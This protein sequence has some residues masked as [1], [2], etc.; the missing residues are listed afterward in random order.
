MA[1]KSSSSR[2]TFMLGGT[3]AA[4]VAGPIAAA[5]LQPALTRS[6]WGPKRPPLVQDELSQWDHLVGSRFHIVGESGK[7]A[8]TL[9]AVV[10]GPADPQRPASLARQQGFTAY[11][12]IEP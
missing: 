7:T 10:H 3:I 8:A 2:R 1:K 5:R 12:E 4:A 11:F 9:A 6:L